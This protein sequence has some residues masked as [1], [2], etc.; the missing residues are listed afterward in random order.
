MSEK[1]ESKKKAKIEALLFAT[2]GL[3]ID[4]IS[5]RTG[6]RKRE[7]EKIL[8]ELEI[9]YL[10]ESKGVQ[11]VN[12]GGL[13]KMSV[14]P[15]HTPNVKDLLPPEMP[16]SLIKTLAIIA[17]NKPIKQSTIVKIRGNKSYGQI[18]KLEKMGFITTEKFGTTQMIDLTEKFFKYFQIVESELKQK[19]SPDVKKK[20]EEIENEDTKI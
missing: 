6:F 18:K 11:V 7:V 4:E 5:K 16:K 20:I 15:E 19:I 13:W 8:E 9:E 14:K 2:N 10:N 17:S 3:T 12:E 1:D